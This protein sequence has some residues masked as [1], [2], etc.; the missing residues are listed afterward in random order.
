[1][2]HFIF[3]LNFQSP[4]NCL[5][6]NCKQYS[7]DGLCKLKSN[8]VLVCEN[9]NFA[10]KLK[11]KNYNFFSY[12]MLLLRKQIWKKLNR[13]P[14]TAANRPNW[15]CKSLVLVLPPP[16]KKVNFWKLGLSHYWA[17]ENTYFMP[18]IRKKLTSQFWERLLTDKYR[19][20]QINKWAE[21]MNL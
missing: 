18:K 10:K 1:M 20:K 14:E 19:D 9:K 16:Q 21:L 17:V 15:T 7:D 5:Q 2:N 11:L 12:V 8:M 4:E 6:E 13:F 3:G